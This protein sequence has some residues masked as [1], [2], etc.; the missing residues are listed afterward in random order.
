MTRVLLAVGMVIA[1]V[2]AVLASPAEAS[3]GAPRWS[4]LADGATLPSRGVLFVHDEA[5]DGDDL[6]LVWR[7]GTAGRW[8]VTPL[9][10]T[11]ARVDYDA[12]SAMGVELFAFPRAP[13][14]R[15]GLD[16][17]WRAPSRLPRVVA[18]SHEQG[19]WTCSSH[20]LLAIE[21]DEPVAAVRVRWTFGRITREL[22]EVPWTRG[23]RPVLALGKI[24]CGGANLDPL[25]LFVGGALELIA[26]RF[27]GSEVAVAGLPPWISTQLVALLP[28]RSSW[29]WDVLRVLVAGLLALIAT[30][31]RLGAG[32]PTAAV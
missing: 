2:I 30:R 29:S 19:A 3:C 1:M 18:L 24:D 32:A 9:S 26:I 11:V 17:R 16:P 31:R 27:D 14:E 8:T 23:G 4:S 21:L 10:T 20:D 12:G 28:V 25:E 6:Q 22:V 7:D 13:G 5:L 15:A